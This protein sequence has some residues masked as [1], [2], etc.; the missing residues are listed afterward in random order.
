MH[1]KNNTFWARTK[2]SNKYVLDIMRNFFNLRYDN[3]PE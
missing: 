2:R 1:N 3:I